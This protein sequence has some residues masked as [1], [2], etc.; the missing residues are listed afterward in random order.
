[1]ESPLG[2]GTEQIRSTAPHMYNS[3][4]YVEALGSKVTG[5]IPEKTSGSKNERIHGPGG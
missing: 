5:S 2:I 4:R 3:I 1:M